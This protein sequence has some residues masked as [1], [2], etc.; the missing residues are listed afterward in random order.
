MWGEELRIKYLYS[1][2]NI[3]P[4]QMWN[5]IWGNS[6]GRSH[7]VYFEE[8]FVKPFYKF[9]GHNFYY[10]LSLETNIFLKP[11]E[12]KLEA[13]INHKW[14]DWYAFEDFTLIKV[15][16]FEGS[17]FFLPKIILNMVAYLEIVRKLGYSNFT[18][19]KSYGI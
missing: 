1:D 15:Y 4:V 18:H 2:K 3:R 10:K 8:Y 13:R 12:I 14:G 6:C 16:G 9:L 7:Y 19:L 5:S 17:T 11:K